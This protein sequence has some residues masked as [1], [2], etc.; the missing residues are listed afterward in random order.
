MEGGAAG[1]V[2]EAQPAPPKCARVTCAICNSTVSSTNLAR[3]KKSKLH[4]DAVLAAAAA[5]AGVLAAAPGAA[6]LQ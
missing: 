1:V 4:R 3:H 5:A 6:V 2:G